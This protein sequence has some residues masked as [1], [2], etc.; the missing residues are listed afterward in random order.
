MGKSFKSVSIIG[1]GIYNGWFL[2]KEELEKGYRSMVNKTFVLDHSMDIEDAVGF[3]DTS[4]YAEPAMI[5][6]FTIDEELE[7]A[8][9][10]LKWIAKKQERGEMPEVSVAF[11]AKVADMEDWYDEDTPSMVDIEFIHLALVT[12]GACSADDGCGV[13]SES[14]DD[15]YKPI[16]ANPVDGHVIPMMRTTELA[17]G[18]VLVEVKMAA[19]LIELGDNMTEEDNPTDGQPVEVRVDVSKCEEI[20]SKFDEA[21]DAIE[22]LKEKNDVLQKANETLRE[23]MEKVVKEYAQMVFA[24]HESDEEPEI[25]EP[26]ELSPH[27]PKAT[28]AEGYNRVTELLEAGGVKRKK[29]L[30][31]D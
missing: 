21:T 16:P 9:V 7:K 23:N 22:E 31:E 10:A 28:G 24:L 27:A 30:V 25:P 4:E 15:W 29:T 14:A 8:D 3:V 13:V 6:S 11:T 1:D 12:A 5:N 20:I 19:Q 18:R 2:P 26:Q 17:D